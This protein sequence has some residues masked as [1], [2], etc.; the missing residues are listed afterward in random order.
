[1]RAFQTNVDTWQTGEPADLPPGEDVLRLTLE[2]HG[3]LVSANRYFLT[4]VA[5]QHDAG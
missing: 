1:M 2:H 5:G 3:V 4:V